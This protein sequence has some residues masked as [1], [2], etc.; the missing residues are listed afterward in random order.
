MRGASTALTGTLAYVA[1]AT[2]ATA[3]GSVQPQTC[4]QQ[5][6]HGQT[7]AESAFRLA[8]GARTGEAVSP[9]AASA[10]SPDQAFPILIPIDGSIPTQ[11]CRSINSQITIQ[12][13]RQLPRYMPSKVFVNPGSKLERVQY[14]ALRIR[15]QPQIAAV[16]T[17]SGQNVRDRALM[18]KIGLLLAVA[19]LVFL[20]IWFWATRRPRPLRAR[21]GIDTSRRI[22]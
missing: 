18:I 5:Q 4:P 17:K 8:Q 20:T 22:E 6:Y 14:Q 11:N 3:A 7:Q 2:G 16:A 21:R 1:F 15:Y 10:I 19:Y 13:R 12:N 9:V